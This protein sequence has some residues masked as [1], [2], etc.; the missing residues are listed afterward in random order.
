MPAELA[1]IAVVTSDNPRTEDP[2]QILADV[3]AGIPAIVEPIVIGD[4][5]TAIRHAIREAQSGD[6][7]LIAGES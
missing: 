5:A 4:R 3:V 6:G 2:E 1:D 7:V